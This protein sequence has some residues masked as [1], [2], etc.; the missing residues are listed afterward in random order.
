[1]R[2]RIEGDITEENKLKAARK[3]LGGDY[4]IKAMTPIKKRVFSRDLVLKQSLEKVTQ[5]YERSLEKMFKDID[6]VLRKK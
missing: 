1:M 4:I 3:L 6:K 2:I 5:E